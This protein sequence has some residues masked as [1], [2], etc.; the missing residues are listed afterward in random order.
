MGSGSVN[1][2]THLRALWVCPEFRARPAP[3]QT[4]MDNNHGS[5][6]ESVGPLGLAGIKT[7]FRGL[8][9]PATKSIGPL[10]QSICVCPAPRSNQDLARARKIRSFW[11]Y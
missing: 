5:R 4:H 2:V 7:V 9:A 11:Y 8:P 1:N 3:G 10:G 6:I